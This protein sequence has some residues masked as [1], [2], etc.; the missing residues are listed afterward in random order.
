MPNGVEQ[1]VQEFAQGVWQGTEEF[2]ESLGVLQERA[3]NKF[4]AYL[5][6]QIQS[7]LPVSSA[8]E[9]EARYGKY[10][11]PPDGPDAR[12][13][14]SVAYNCR[15]D[16]CYGPDFAIR[17]MMDN[18]ALMIDLYIMITK[19][20]IEMNNAV[21]LDNLPVHTTLTGWGGKGGSGGGH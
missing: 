20:Q 5:E 6:Q 17:N 3:A 8:A 18:M 1:R 11:L 14:A 12:Y 21:I 9:Y 7:A 10:A 19:L 2:A 13:W 15:N 16:E 4:D